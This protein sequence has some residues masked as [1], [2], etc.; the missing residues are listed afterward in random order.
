MKCYILGRKN[1]ER[2]REKNRRGKLYLVVEKKH[3]YHG[4]VNVDYDWPSLTLLEAIFLKKYLICFS[5]M[6]SEYILQVIKLATAGGEMYAMAGEEESRYPCLGRDNM[7]VVFRQ[8]GSRKWQTW[9]LA[10]GRNEVQV[11]EAPKRIDQL[12]TVTYETA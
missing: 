7:D 10:V 12:I 1:I 8:Q 2:R 11:L 3:I 6:N 5:S 9:G 4:L